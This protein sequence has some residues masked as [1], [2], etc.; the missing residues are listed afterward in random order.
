[1][2][3][4]SRTCVCY[5]LDVHF[6]TP[7]K[8]E[9]F[10]QRLKDIRQKLTPASSPLLD[11]FCLMSASCDAVDPSDSSSS[12]TSASSVGP[13]VKSFMTN[14]GKHWIKLHT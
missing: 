7:E 9:V 5:T 3:T 13:T 8:K 12:Q 4:S 11:N 1:M 2:A 6:L 10:V 14:S